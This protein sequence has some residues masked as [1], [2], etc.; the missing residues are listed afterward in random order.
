MTSATTDADSDWLTELDVIEDAWNVT[1]FHHSHLGMLPIE[2]LEFIVRYTSTG[3]LPALARINPQLRELAEQKLYSSIDLTHVYAEPAQV[4]WPLH[5]TLLRRPDL[6]QAI[7]GFTITAYDQFDSVEV[8]TSVIFPGDTH[9]CSKA[10]VSM[11][12]MV[13]LGRIVMEL[14]LNVKRVHL[15]LNQPLLPHDEWSSNTTSCRELAHD[16]LSSSTLIPRFDSVSAHQLQFPGLQ[17]LTRLRFDGAE[18]HWVLAKLPCLQDIQLTRPC[19]ILPDEAPNEI[20]NS[21]TRLDISARSEILT[22]GSRNYA[23]F[24]A[25]L[26]HFPSLEELQVRT[27][28]LDIDVLPSSAPGPDELEG[29]RSYATLIERL[30]PVAA[31][32]TT[33][34]LGVY[35]SDTGNDRSA[36]IFLNQVR[37]AHSFQHFKV[38]KNLVVPQRCL[39]RSIETLVDPLPSPAK[40]LPASLEH[41]GIHCPQVFILDWLER[42]QKVQDKL[43]ALSAIEL[44]CQKPY[45]DVFPLFAFE[46]LEHPALELLPDIGIGWSIVPRQRDWESD[47]DNYDKEISGAIEWLDGFGT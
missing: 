17:K 22:R 7:E 46:N 5:C 13:I 24:K 25:F 30:S 38:L 15:I 8:D 39:L 1:A 31:T 26:A 16:P 29:A 28:D 27:Y 21:V 42:I 9:F 40:I 10:E 45:G 35:N 2:L 43:P 32:L 3:D 18:F 19:V 11:N 14:L 4:L 6:A 44:Y 23:T 36:N 34:N 33:L 37:P 20:S 41:L 47:W 12:Q